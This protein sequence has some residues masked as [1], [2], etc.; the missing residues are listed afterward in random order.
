MC[1]PCYF[2]GPQIKRHPTN[3]TLLLESKAV[4]PCMTLGYPKPEVSWL[5]GDD[6][7]KVSVRFYVEKKK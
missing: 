1:L 2:S 5:K 3:V 4:L 7:I 6:L